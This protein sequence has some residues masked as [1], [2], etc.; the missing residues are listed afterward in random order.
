MKPWRTELIPQKAA[1]QISLADAVFTIGSCFAQKMGNQ[2]VSNK[3]KTQV[4]PFGTV[5]NPHS[6]HK[7]ITSCLE[8][9]PAEENSYVG[10]ENLFFHYDF[11]SR[12]AA[13]TKDGLIEKLKKLIETQS[14][15]LKQSNVLIIT[16]GTAFVYRR[17]DNQQIVSN[18]HKVAANQF[19][20][21][22]LTV[23]KTVRSFEQM[24]D[25]LLKIN[26]VLKIIL[27]VSP[28]RHTKDGLEQNTVSKSV[29][30]LACD[31]LSQKKGIAYFP[32]YELMMDDL[33]DY[34]FYITDRIHPT[35]EAEEYIWEKFVETFLDSEA[36]SF[37]QEWLEVN[38]A[39][40]HRPFN[41][42][43]FAHQTF[44]KNTL[45]KLQNLSQQTDVSVEI[46]ELKSR[47]NHE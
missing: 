12:H 27:T 47:M 11:H 25:A 26:P 3:I 32:A 33:R 28:V 41:E 36:K 7:L 17:K 35:E 19:T 4:N 44:L 15:E 13:N 8:K 9:S 5:Y 31:Q 16:Y 2:L 18:C 29:L 1:F 30:R 14:N 45:T 24:Y 10:R 34:R 43:T 40:Q 22:L 6:I 20:K 39:L 46:A 38:S 23:D 37:F 21:E 42:Q